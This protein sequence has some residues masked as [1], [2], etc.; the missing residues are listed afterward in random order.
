MPPPDGG[1]ARPASALYCARVWGLAVKLARRLPHP[2]S[3]WLASLG[4]K[5][6]WLSRPGRRPVV[7][8]NVLPVLQGDREAA[9]AVTRQ[10]FRQ[11]AVKLADLCLYES[12]CSIRRLFAEMS[13]WEHFQ[14]AQAHGRGVLLLTIHLGN[15]E[16]GSPLLT[17][18]GVKLQV[19]TGPEPH[20]ELTRLR[21]AARARW[22]IETIALGENPFAVVEIIRRLEANNCVA[23]LM[24]RPPAGTAARVTLFGRPFDASGS[25][26]ELARASGCALLPV[27]LPLTPQG[28]AACILPEIPYD[29]PA[30]RSREARLELTQ[31]ITT[32][33]E[34]AI[35]R[36]PDQWYHFVPIWPTGPNPAADEAT[37]R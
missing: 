20:P 16:F 30:L 31:R 5:F 13:G 28:Y 26:A 32:A 8:E 1:Q 6:Y 18:R 9:R 23:L 17:E 25:A 15:W 14:A 21:Q 27:Y 19:I 33:F 37:R 24:D 10:V 11:F 29:R 7:F 22:G 35:R 4:G 2:L 34:P 36:H 3:R 12:G